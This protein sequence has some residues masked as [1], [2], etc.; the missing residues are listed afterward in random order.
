[1]NNE[2]PRIPPLCGTK[3]V[4]ELL[5]ITRQNVPNTRKT[6]GFPDP[7]THIG[8]RPFWLESDILEFRDKRNHRKSE[9]ILR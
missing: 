7:I 1:M 8:K 9:G 2:R 4:A 6:K 3:E 5:G